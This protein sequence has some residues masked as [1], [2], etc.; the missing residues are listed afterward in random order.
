[1]ARSYGPGRR[2]EAVVL[3]GISGLLQRAPTRMRIGFGHA[4]GEIAHRADRRHREL[5]RANLVAALGVGADEA[6]RITRRTFRF[7]GRVLAETLAMPAYLGE[8]CDRAVRV[9]DVE[10]LAR[11]FARGRGVLVCSAHI[12]NWELAG[13]RQ[14]RAGFPMDYISRPLD[15]PWLYDRLVAWRAQGGIRTHEKHGAARS[16]MKTLREGRSLAFVVDQNMTSPPRLF[17][18]FFG[19][20][21]ATPPT[22]AHLALRL[23][24]PVVP[25]WTYPEA[26]GTY[27]LQYLPEIEPPAAGTFDERVYA[28]TLAATRHVEDWVRAHPDTW[29]WLHDRWKTRPGPGEDPG[30]GVTVTA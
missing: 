23:E 8:A 10:H 11:A 16:M 21:A 20:A 29:I 14:C 1:M 4:L 15:N 25:A 2:A 30:P 17:V 26:D 13:L 3:L 18:P 12:G 5:A 9:V 24:V 19:R 27:T 7:F 28:L 22:M 6:A